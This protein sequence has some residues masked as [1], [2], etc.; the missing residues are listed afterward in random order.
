MI[1]PVVED[2]HAAQFEYLRGRM[3]A[4]RDVRR[5]P[6]AT[7]F[8]EAEHLRACVAP[9]IPNPFF[10][11]VFISGAAQLQDVESALALFEQHGMKPQLDLGSGAT[12]SALARCLSQRGFVHTQSYPVLIQPERDAAE[13]PESDIL[14]TRVES[15]T[16]L[17]AFKD[18][19]VR[20]WQ[21]EAWLAPSLQSYMEH[22][23]SLPGW[24]LYLASQQ[25]VPIGIG[26]LFEHSGVAYLA[27]AAT[28]PESR[29]RGAQS[30]L[31][32]R[33]IADARQNGARV[34]FSR[35]EFGS[36]S[37]RNLERAGF[38]SRYTAAIW[39]EQ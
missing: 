9:G 33:R 10:N 13:S 31:I 22:W 26:V 6:N 18:V 12:S 19:Y 8:F 28:A 4:M 2:V 15:V 24:T 27:D 37:L 3:N 38:E 16:A 29:T 5:D 21:V 14:V 7:C 35:A 1:E 39:T 11:Q 17:E 32:A 30:A 36:I 25:N 20:G 34:V 23:L